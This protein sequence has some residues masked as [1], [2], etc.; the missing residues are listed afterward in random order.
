M[1]VSTYI[2]ICI[3]YTHLSLYMCI[4]IYIQLYIS[5]SISLSIYIYIYIYIYRYTHIYT[6]I[7]V[8]VSFDVFSKS[9]LPFPQGTRSL[10]VSDLHR[11]GLSICRDARGLRAHNHQHPKFMVWIRTTCDW[12]VQPVQ[13]RMMLYLK[14]S[15]LILGV[16][17]VARERPR[18]F[19]WAWP[20]ALLHVHAR[21]GPFQ[22]MCISLSLCI[23][24]YICTHIM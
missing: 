17:P 20:P 24:I 6:H 2:Y 4:Y 3:Y 19:R 16:W 8:H 1:C 11:V 22:Y 7:C 13:N 10:S 12:A 5:L 21:P 14:C 9:F 18:S 15:S 23:Y